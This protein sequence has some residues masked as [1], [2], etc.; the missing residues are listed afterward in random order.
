MQVGSNYEKPP[1]ILLHQAARGS[2][3]FKGHIE[4]TLLDILD[5]LC[6][7]AV[8]AAKFFEGGSCDVQ[9][10]NLENV[11]EN[12]NTERKKLWKMPL[13]EYIFRGGPKTSAGKNVL[14]TLFKLC[15][16]VQL[17]RL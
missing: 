2:I 14:R 15:S 17:C 13:W 6:P 12:F 1:D 3:R 11:I 10:A 4:R 16:C 8:R 9:F 5:V 7:T